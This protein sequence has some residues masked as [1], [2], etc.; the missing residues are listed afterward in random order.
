V[1]VRIG[2]LEAGN[3]LADSGR[4]VLFG[5]ARHNQLTPA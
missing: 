3:D 5:F 4:S 2:A 1:C